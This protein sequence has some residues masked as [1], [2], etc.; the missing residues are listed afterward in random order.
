MEGQATSGNFFISSY[1]FSNFDLF[2]PC[3]ITCAPNFDAF[4]A[5]ALPIPSVDPVI[6]RFLFFKILELY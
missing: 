1:K 2:L 5:R 4:I 3:R 6:K